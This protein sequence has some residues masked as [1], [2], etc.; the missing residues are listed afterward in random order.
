MD[1]FKIYILRQR[2]DWL[3][4]YSL[5]QDLSDL[6]YIQYL[7]KDDEKYTTINWK[8]S[9]LV[10]EYEYWDWLLIVDIIEKIIT[11]D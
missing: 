8:I 6:S 1:N 4:N 5:F 11:I 3:T 2:W 10:W 7:K 9:D